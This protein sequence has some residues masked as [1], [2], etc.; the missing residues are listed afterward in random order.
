VDHVVAGTTVNNRAVVT[1][2]KN[3]VRP[4]PTGDEIAA[5]AAADQIITA[6]TM[7]RLVTHQVDD[8]VTMLGSGQR[9]VASPPHNGGDVTVA[10]HLACRAD[11]DGAGVAAV[12]AA[13]GTI[14]AAITV[15]PAGITIREVSFTPLQRP[16]PGHR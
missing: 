8:H 7:D 1:T 12:A 9:G 15:R 5:L 11:P 2:D 6:A 13:T 16:D 4:W 14:A 3:V 10:H